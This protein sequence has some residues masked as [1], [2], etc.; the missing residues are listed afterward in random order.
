MN[1]LG[2][3]LPPVHVLPLTLPPRQP[4]VISHGV[5]IEK[6][7]GVGEGVEGGQ[8]LDNITVVVSVV[9]NGH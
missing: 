7:P 2:L 6:L 1:P 5:E 9:L 4:G 8:G 3:L